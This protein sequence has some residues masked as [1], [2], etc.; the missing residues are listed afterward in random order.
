VH[1]DSIKCSIVGGHVTNNREILFKGKSKSSPQ[2]KVV[3]TNVGTETNAAVTVDGSLKQCMVAGSLS[4][5]G[6]TFA[7]DDDDD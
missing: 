4:T 1:G 2:P 7:E 3:H 6:I 5:N